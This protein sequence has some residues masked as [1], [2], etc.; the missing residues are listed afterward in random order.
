M[1]AKLQFKMPPIS[2]SLNPFD[3]NSGGKRGV[4]QAATQ[5][6]KWLEE[7]LKWGLIAI[8]DKTKYLYIGCSKDNLILDNNIKMPARTTSI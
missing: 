1:Y 8:M 2:G 7:Y 4:H 5:L 3:Q 6:G